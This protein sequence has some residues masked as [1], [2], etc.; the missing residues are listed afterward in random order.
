MDLTKDRISDLIRKIAIPSSIGTLFQTLYNIVDAKFAGLIDPGAITGI[1]K[2][3][4]I[5]F[6]IIGTTVGLSAGVT[7]LIS[8][9]LGKKDEN[10]ASFLFSQS[11][12]IS[13]LAALIVTTIGIYGTEP[14]LIFLKTGPE[15]IA[16]AKDYMLSLIH[17]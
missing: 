13:I 14:I 4:P 1:A 9:A 7:A 11:I 17:I 15:V 6:I 3:F 12:L 16:Y 5:Y 2:S 10:T 8:N